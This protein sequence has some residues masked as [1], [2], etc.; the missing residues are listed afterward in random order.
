MGVI[1]I[2]SALL[3]FVL[4]GYLTVKSKFFQFR[5]LKLVFKVTFGRLIKSKDLLGFKAMSIALGSTIGI[6]NII[7][8]ASAIIIGGAG[9]VFWLLV[10]GFLGMIIKYSEIHICVKEAG[11]AGRSFGGPMYVFKN[12]AKSRFKFLGTV[13]AFVCVLASFFAGNLMQSRSIYRFAEIGFD[14]KFLPITVFILPLLLIILLG[15]DKLYQNLSAIFVPIMALFYIGS[16]L[17]IILDNLIYV[18]NALMS[19]FSGAFGIKQISGGISGAVISKAIRT[20]VMKGLFTHEAGMG[21]SPIAHASAENADPFCQGCWGIIEVFIDTV[22]V[23]MVTALAVLSSPAYLRGT[24]SDPFLL[25]CEIFKSTFGSFGMKALS[26]SACCF[27]FA[28][29]IGWS[30]YGIKSLEFL[31]NNKSIRKLYIIIFLLL[32]PLSKALNESFVWAL[33]DLF[34]SSM[35]IPNSVLL[36]CLGGDSVST[37][38]KIKSTLEFKLHW[39]YNFKKEGE[40]NALHTLPEKMLSH[41]G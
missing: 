24:F 9:A 23:C 34:N 37:L 36:L 13:F 22:V 25:I 12:K 21:S 31:T 7:G 33:T 8:V 39:K 6:G 26:L 2:F 40:K 10:T 35:L 4:G 30:F 5:R 29:I 3:L 19:I 15:K 27:A 28:S 1:S 11:E 17:L 20:G 38:G 14:L 18:P 32:V 41:K 16:A